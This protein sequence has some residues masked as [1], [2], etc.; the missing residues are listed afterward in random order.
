LTNLP[1][2][3]CV[4]VLC[5]PVKYVTDVDHLL[6]RG[7][8]A[9]LAEMDG[10]LTLRKIGDGF[11]TMVELHH[12]KIRGPGFEPIT[13][14]LEKIT[15]D[16]LVDKSGKQIPTVHAV[17]VTDQEVEGQAAKSM[18]DEDH[19]LTAVLANPSLSITEIAARCGWFWS[20]GQPAKSRAQKALERLGTDRLAKKGRGGTWVL[21]EAGK[22]AA[23]KAALRFDNLENR[24]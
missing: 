16:R 5:H 9:F 18:D 21:T 24:T 7:G 20:D 2:E 12:N 3:P 11:A 1:G 19:V 10:N 14:R 13:F 8:G 4:L 22:T 6:P 15:C 17:V 23:R